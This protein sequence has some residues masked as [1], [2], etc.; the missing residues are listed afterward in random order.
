M[1]NSR[2]Q[3]LRA[4][5]LPL[6][7]T[8]ACH[9]IAGAIVAYGQV[10]DG[11]AGELGENREIPT[12]SQ[13]T[14]W[15]FAFPRSN[16]VAGSYA[17]RRFLVPSNHLGDDSAHNHYDAVYAVA[18]GIVKF[19][20]TASGYGRAVVIEHLLP[21]GSNVVSIYGHLCGH[22]GYP[23]ISNGSTV[24]KGQVIGYVGDD[25]ENGDGAE[26]I[27]LG[28]RKNAYD[29]Y[30]CGY[31]GIPQ[32][33]ADHYWD[34]TAYINDRSNSLKVTSGLSVN[35]SS[36]L[37]GSV[38]SISATVF[39]YYY[40]GGNFQ[41]RVVFKLGGATEYTSPTATEWLNPG[42]SRFLNFDQYLAQPGGYT[43]TLEL[44][45]PGT[46][47]W[48]PVGTTGGG[49]NPRSFTVVPLG[50]T[51]L[52]FSAMSVDKGIELTWSSPY[53]PGVAGWNVY[54]SRKEDGS[55]ERINELIIVPRSGSFF[56]RDIDVDCGKRYSYRLE[57]VALDSSSIVFDPILTEVYLKCNPGEVE[58]VTGDSKRE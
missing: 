42:D 48:W 23:L 6:L 51:L 57:S 14:A 49:V 18:N 56:F 43:A 26:H 47:T 13:E 35:P 17:G 37:A 28:M 8:A 30:F 19:A 15:S 16:F 39:N 5:A 34:P 38:F 58:E 44:K 7:L 50:V 45:A 29:G 36:P 40:Y 46:Q 1:T 54:R 24:T 12:K 22:S 21:D 27:H 32:C 20:S 4:Y 10:G 9:M 41:F 11:G 25:A 3:F 53:G 31:T 33:T 55:Y 2:A 52:D